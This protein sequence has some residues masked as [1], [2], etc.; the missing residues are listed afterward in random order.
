MYN[1]LASSCKTRIGIVGG[2]HCYFADYN[3]NC[4]FGEGTTSP[5]PTISRDQQH[6]IVAQLLFPYLDLCLKAMLLLSKYIISD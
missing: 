2:G 1:A 4:C 3:F 5:Q 6:E